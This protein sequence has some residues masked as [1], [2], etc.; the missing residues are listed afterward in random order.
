MNKKRI[1]CFFTSMLFVFFG[2]QSMNV[3]F[4]NDINVPIDSITKKYDMAMLKDSIDA[5]C[6]KTES[7]PDSLQFN[8]RAYIFKRWISDTLCFIKD[9]YEIGDD[10]L[11]LKT[12][13]SIEC[14]ICDGDQ[15][16][17]S[18]YAN[19]I[20]DM[21]SFYDE[22][23]AEDKKLKL[24]VET[25]YSPSFGRSLYDAKTL[26]KMCQVISPLQ[27]KF[28]NINDNFYIKGVDVYDLKK[29]LMKRYDI[30]IKDFE[31]KIIE[32]KLVGTLSIKLA[33]I[34]ILYMEDL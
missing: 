25:E 31:K 6:E 12:I 4:E 8:Y 9:K 29:G 34:P 10:S 30:S 14:E 16:Y 33:D 28:Y 22:I 2:G 11:M 13:N 19:E 21:L 26:I 15:S 20:Y 3:I 24:V 1:S 18:A 32:K 27:I 23:T 5:I 17:D 7:L